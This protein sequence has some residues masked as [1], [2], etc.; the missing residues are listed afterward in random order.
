[1]ALCEHPL[2]T[3]DIARTAAASLPWEM[4]DGKRLAVFGATGMIGRFLIDVLMYRNAHCGAN[5]AV[6]AVSRSEETANACFAPYRDDPRFSFAAQDVAAPLRTD[7]PKADYLIHAASNTH[8]RAYATDP[9]GTITANVIG[10]KNLLDYGVEASCRRFLFLSSVEIYGESRTDEQVFSESDCGY[11]DCNTPRAG[12]PEGK[13]TGEA[14][15]QA[16]IAQ[17]EMDAVIVRLPRVYGPTLRASDSKASSQ[18]LHKALA[19][20]DIVLKSEGK[21]FYSYLYVADA[22]T[23][24]L[25]VLLKGERGQ[26]Y[27]AADPRSD[28]TLRE[29]AQICAD[30]AGK[31]VVFDLPDAVERA[32]YSKATRAI[33]NGDKLRTL[34]WQ[35]EKTITSGITRTLNILSGKRTGGWRE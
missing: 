2:Y 10:T 8:P 27:N 12:Y 34:G 5:C 31:N 13:R 26:A 16:Y 24:L 6:L 20:E 1:M 28:V 3:E 23:A 32:G 9:V 17:Y 4:L 15:C 30:W 11:L 18:F 29:L 22:V 14:L 21:Q 35:A 33:L 19:G 25:T 7:F